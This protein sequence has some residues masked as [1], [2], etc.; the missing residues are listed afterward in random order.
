M[1]KKK[2]NKINIEDVLSFHFLH[3]E[4]CTNEWRYIFL[5]CPFNGV[6]ADEEITVTD[7]KIAF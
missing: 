6:G 7:K 1:N 3:P 5:R 4:W 2:L